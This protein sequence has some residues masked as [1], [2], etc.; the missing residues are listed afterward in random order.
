M[1]FRLEVRGQ[2]PSDIDLVIDDKDIQRGGLDLSCSFRTP[3]V[4]RLQDTAS[5]PIIQSATEGEWEFSAKGTA[6]PGNTAPAE[7]RSPLIFDRILSRACQA[8]P[9]A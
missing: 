4:N 2:G 5:K 7:C 3:I 6:S 8:R 1:T 9:H